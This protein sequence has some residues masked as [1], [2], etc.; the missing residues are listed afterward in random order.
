MGVIHFVIHFECPL[1]LIEVILNKTKFKSKL[2]KT[3]LNFAELR[4]FHMI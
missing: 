2:R 4:G 3:N 1:V